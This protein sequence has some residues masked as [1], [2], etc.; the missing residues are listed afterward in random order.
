MDNDLLRNIPPGLRRGI[1]K[2]LLRIPKEP[3]SEEGKLE[4][5]VKEYPRRSGITI[6]KNL[7]EVLLSRGDKLIRGDVE[8]RDMKVLNTWFNEYKHKFSTY[9][10]P[11]NTFGFIDREYVYIEKNTFNEIMLRQGYEPVEILAK[12]L[13]L[14]LTVPTT[15]PR[16]LHKKGHICVKL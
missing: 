11:D 15:A 9:P 3:Y 16:S 1:P 13:E 14:N 12:W 2:G 5:L 4:K 10:D 8:T 6:R 7:G